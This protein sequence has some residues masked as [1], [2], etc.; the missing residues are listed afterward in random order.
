[1]PAAS[2]W[3]TVQEPAAAGWAGWLAALAYPAPA[4]QMAAAAASTAFRRQ[5]P[6]RPLTA[7]RPGGS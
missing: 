6:G 2:W 7:N 3:Y 4:T 5:L 1:V